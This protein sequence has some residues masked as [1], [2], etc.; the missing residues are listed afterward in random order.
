MDMVKNNMS[1]TLQTL[2]QTLVISLLAIPRRFFCVWFF[3]DLRCGVPLFVVILVI[4]KC[5]NRGKLMLNVR[6]AEDHLYGSIA[7]HLAVAGD[8]FDGVFLCCP[9]SHEM[10]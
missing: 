7:V 2:L 9:F 3:G 1:S 5:K 4:Y 6:P 8:V 10:S